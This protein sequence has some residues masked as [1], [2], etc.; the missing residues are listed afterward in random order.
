M[1]R[2]DPISVEL[3]LCLILSTV[4]I[5]ILTHTVRG[6]TYKYTVIIH[7][8][9]VCIYYVLQIVSI[10]VSGTASLRYSP[11]YCLYGTY[12]YG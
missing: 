10:C 4:S 2:L 1:V 3:Y 9:R 8:V 12:G 6:T 11:H 5:A 7:D